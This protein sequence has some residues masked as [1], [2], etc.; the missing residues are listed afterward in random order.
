VP[1]ALPVK[2]H[3]RWIAIQ[4][5]TQGSVTVDSGAAKALQTDGKSLL[6]AG[7]T[8]C[9]GEFEEGD[10]IQVCTEDGTEIA[11][12]IT[13]IGALEIS[14]VMGLGPNAIQEKLPQVSSSVVIHRDCLVLLD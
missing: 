9:E 11:Q 12:G 2:S 14:K 1:S 13:S 3:K 8:A 5:E 10:V 4:D 6:A 7:I